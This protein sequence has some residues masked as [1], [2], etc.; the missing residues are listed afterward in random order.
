[1]FALH[2]AHHSETVLDDAPATR[3][4]QSQWRVGN[5]ISDLGTG[6]SLVNIGK[7]RT[8]RDPDLAATAAHLV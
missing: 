5:A 3:I 1:V 8:L 4:V 2:Y 7:T 6:P